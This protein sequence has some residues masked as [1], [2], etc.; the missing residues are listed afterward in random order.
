MTIHQAMLAGAGG[1]ASWKGDLALKLCQLDLLSAAAQGE[2]PSTSGCSNMSARQGSRS[3]QAISAAL[4]YWRDSMLPM[5]QAAPARQLALMT[6]ALMSPVPCKLPAT[7]QERCTYALYCFAAT[8][9]SAWEM[10]RLE[11]IC[12]CMPAT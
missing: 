2:T 12:A 5:W 9:R 11:H 3:C 6:H 4:F 7:C 8:A 10:C 1:E